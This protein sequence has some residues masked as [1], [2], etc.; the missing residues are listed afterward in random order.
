MKYPYSF[1]KIVGMNARVRID[2]NVNDKQKYI[3]SSNYYHCGCENYQKLLF[4]LIYDYSIVY[5][6]VLSTCELNVYVVVYVD[7]F[8]HYNIQ[9]IVMCEN[10][11]KIIYN[12]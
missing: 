5:T 9:T 3:K 7:V 2:R 6:D 12:K 1:F 4:F 8:E 11:S 10:I